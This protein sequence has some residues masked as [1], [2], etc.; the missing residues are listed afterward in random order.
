MWIW[1]HCIVKTNQ[2]KCE[3]IIT[4]Q[5]KQNAKFN[6]I[7]CIIYFVL[8]HFQCIWFMV[9]MSFFFSVIDFISLFTWNS[10]FATPCAHMYVCVCKCI[11]CM[12]YACNDD[13]VDFAMLYT[14]HCMFF[15]IDALSQMIHYTKHTTNMETIMHSTLSSHTCTSTPTCMI[16][17]NQILNAMQARG[18][19]NL[20]ASFPCN[21]FLNSEF[22]CR[23]FEFLMLPICHRSSI[24]WF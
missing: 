22:K 4:K 8:F 13:D 17:T 21:T 11:F 19:F 12:Q 10:L 23:V 5:Q 14:I 18:I 3:K 1:V 6:F 16:R 9:E 24:K 15:F 20:F 7:L 2:T